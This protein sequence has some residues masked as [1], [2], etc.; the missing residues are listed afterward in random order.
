MKYIMFEVT[1]GDLKRKVPIIFPSSLVHSEIAKTLCKVSGLSSRI[2]G[3][4]ELSIVTTGWH[5]KYTTLGIESKKD[6]AKI[7]NNYDYSFGM[8]GAMVLIDLEKIFK[9]EDN[10][11]P[12]T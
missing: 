7:I 1:M 11:D 4:G 5:R 9:G 12:K 6:D 10:D 3:A 8:E 2:V